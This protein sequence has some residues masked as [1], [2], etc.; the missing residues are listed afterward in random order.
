M[1]EV[2]GKEADEQGDAAGDG[3][4]EELEGGPATVFCAIDDDQEVHRDQ[5]CFKADE[6]E[7]KVVREEDTVAASGKKQQHGIEGTW[8]LWRSQNAKKGHQRRKSDQ[9]VADAVDAKQELCADCW[10]PV[11][12]DGSREVECDGLKQR[13][14]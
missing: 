13:G 6:E 8:H 5:D 12:A 14:G 4:E 10:N 9:Q 11:V 3:V 2:E 7:Q 1:L